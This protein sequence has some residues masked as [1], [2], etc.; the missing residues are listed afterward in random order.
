MKVRIPVSV[1]E[2]IDRLTILELKLKHATDAGLK[3]DI[4]KSLDEFEAASVPI[5]DALRS[6]EQLRQDLAGVNARLWAVEDDLRAWETE[7]KFD[8][9]FIAL[10]RSVYQLNDQRAAIKKQIDVQVGSDLSDVK[11]YRS[12]TSGR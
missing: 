10:A 8:E 11:I 7:Q 1:G 2:F 6:L 12:D 4:Q 3:G 9:G 5:V